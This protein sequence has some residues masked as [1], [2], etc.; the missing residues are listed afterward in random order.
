MPLLMYWH[1][2]YPV[3]AAGAPRKT[4]AKVRYLTVNVPTA[5]PGK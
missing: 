4:A 5:E 1:D 2:S 3:T